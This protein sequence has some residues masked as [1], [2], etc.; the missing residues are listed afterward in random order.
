[1][2]AEISALLEQTIVDV[3]DGWLEHGHF[4]VDVDPIDIDVPRMPAPCF[5][6]FVS[7][8]YA[9]EVAPTRR[10]DLTVSEWLNTRFA[11]GKAI[12][13]LEGLAKDALV[14]GMVDRLLW[15]AFLHRPPQAGGVSVSAARE[16]LRSGSHRHALESRLWNV[17]LERWGAR[18]ITDV[19]LA[20]RNEHGY[21][22]WWPGSE[23][24]CGE[25]L[26]VHTRNTP[27]GLLDVRVMRYEETDEAVRGYEWQA[28][29]APV[30]AEGWPSAAACGMVYRF[31][32]DP[33]S[34]FPFGDTSN[35]LYA[36]DA[37][38]DVDVMQ[39]SSLREQHPEADDMAMDGDFCFVWLW[40]RRE[41]SAPGAGRD[42]LLGA[43]TDLKRRFNRLAT[44]V[45]DLKPYQFEP[46]E[47]DAIPEPALISVA[48]LEAV[49]RLQ[50]YVES[51]R[52][53]LR[54]NLVLIVNRKKDDFRSALAEIGAQAL[55]DYGVRRT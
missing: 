42:C 31:K 20:P 10:V 51:L 46:L 50:A 5:R 12:T 8:V 44:V 53:D 7:G 6:E 35:M 36:A 18:L 24:S 52:R 34:G 55:I 21:R 2:N 47:G 49:D 25:A 41:G 11:G 9:L 3:Y 37:V 23:S 54:L 28:R 32:R 17:F 43:L 19:Y 16:W 33:A 48:R 30:D 27:S 40:E 45:L 22:R 14:T 13:R 39:V 4:D 15:Q 26:N 38:A 29:L 1:M